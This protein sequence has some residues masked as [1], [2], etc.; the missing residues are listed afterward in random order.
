MGIRAHYEKVI[1]L[2]CFLL[3]FCNVGLASTSFN[4]YQ[5]YIV[6]LPG[7]G[8]SAGSAIIGVRTFLSLV[9]MFVVVRFYQLVDY[10]RGACIAC[11][12]TAVSM[13]VYGFAGSFPAFC[14]AAALGGIG[15][16]LGGMVC[17]TYLINRWFKTDVGTAIGIAAVGSGVASIVVPACAEWVIRSFSLA[18]SFWL[19][20][21]LAVVI[22]AACYAL[23][24]DKPSDLG[25]EPYVNPKWVERHADDVVHAE[26]GAD[27]PVDHGVHLPPRARVLFV[28]ACV[29]V[30]AVSVSAPTFLSVLL[31][32]EGYGHQFAALM[33]S[34]SGFVLTV[35]KG[36]MGRLF[37]LLGGVWGTVIAFAAF[38]AG[39]V[40]LILGSGGNAALVWAGCIVY[41]F[42]LA[43]GS[44]GIPIWSLN[45]S[46]PAE[47][48]RTVRTFQ[49][50]Y[51]MGSFA[52]SF[53]PGILKDVLG[54]YVVS[55]VM[56][57]AM[58]VVALVLIVCIY[59]RYHG[60]V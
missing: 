26:G 55:Y 6:A 54:S 9:C 60:R 15:Y 58:L 33:L 51:A 14:F 22:A 48:V 1:A 28:G 44:T 53:V 57:T 18:A 39:L 56:M 16:G 17:T 31:V 11:L 50:G 34:V 12:F 45:L 43:I 59:A 36:A 20:A 2:C 38:I 40:L 24:R 46:T 49:T 32:S 41:A 29:L 8:D 23:L 19:E 35:G 7:I 42:G 21:V 4:V 47:R 52:F 13:V 25:L 30:G 5:P 37:D 10:R 3:I 27:V